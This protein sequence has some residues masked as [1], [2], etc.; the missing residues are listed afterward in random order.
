MN[1]QELTKKNGNVIVLCSFEELLT[2]YYKVRSMAEVIP[3]ANGSG[4]YIIQCPF[5]KS[6]GYMKH[7]LYVKNDLTVGHCFKCHRAFINVT[8]TIEYN[9][10]GPTKRKEYCHDLVKLDNENWTLDMYYNEFDEHD[11]I[12]E[13]Y[14]ASRHKYLPALAK[15][16][17]FKFY[18]HNVIMPFFFHGE[19]I[20]YQMRFT[21]KNPIRYFFPPISNKPIYTLEKIVP[22]NGN[23][24]ISE[25]VFDI[26][27]DLL[28]FPDKFPVA[29]LGSTVSDYQL[30]MIRTYNPKSI[31]VYMDETKLSIGVLKKLQSVI[32]NVD[33]HYRKSDGQDP[34]EYLKYLIKSNKFYLP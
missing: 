9:I 27:S 18:N 13:R 31:T 4:E 17:G 12:G 29:I 22:N 10:K 33:Y 28:L 11:E 19:L 24:I 3:N 32:D 15:L 20:Y 26:C 23:L 34:E 2:D 1:Y 14:L 25:G 6:E 7:K 16:L 8:D 21:N 5:C 30:E